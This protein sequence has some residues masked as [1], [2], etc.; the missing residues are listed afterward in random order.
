[1][2]EALLAGGV[3]A[4]LCYYKATV[5]GFNREDDT[6]RYIAFIPCNLLMYVS[7]KAIPQSRYYPPT[8]SPI[9]M[10]AALRDRVGIA[11]VQK[12]YF[13]DP[14]F[15]D[16]NVTVREYDVDHWSLLSHAKDISSD[17]DDWL[18][19]VVL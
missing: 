17:L 9:F 18:A 8:S 15:K 14:K 6:S 19:K 7:P 13:T 16:H 1:M 5:R 2:S 11:E 10:G 4:P 3:T 12:G